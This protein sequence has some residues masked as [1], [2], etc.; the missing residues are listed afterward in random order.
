NVGPPTIA[1]WP[2]VV[3]DGPRAPAP[4]S[5][6]RVFKTKGCASCHSV[7]GTAGIGPTLKGVYGTMRHFTDG[8]IRVADAEYI[9]H[10]TTDHSAEIVQGFRN[11][12][13]SYRG[14]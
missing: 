6:G 7:D 12:G 14:L 4:V 1:A 3:P 9:R 13:P 11:Q 10:A 5:A 8:S 2:P